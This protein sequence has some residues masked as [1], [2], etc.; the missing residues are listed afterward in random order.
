VPQK[1]SEV[2]ELY[3]SKKVSD[4]LRKEGV[5]IRYRR[6]LITRK[7]GDKYAVYLTSYLN[8]Q[9]N[10]QMRMRSV[11]DPRNKYLIW[12]SARNIRVG[13]DN[14]TIK[15]LVPDKNWKPMNEK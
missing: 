12:F 2:T 9:L 7:E 13:I 10:S 5:W 3:R 11:K 4:K 14:L 1:G 15:R 6:D 8:G